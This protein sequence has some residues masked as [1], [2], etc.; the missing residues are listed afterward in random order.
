[1][2][3]L[4]GERT[5]RPTSLILESEKNPMKAILICLLALSFLAGMVASP[6]ESGC[7]AV[8]VKHWQVSKEFTLAVAEAMPAAGYDFKPKPEEMTF[9]QLMV[10]IAAQNSDSCADATGTKPPPSMPSSSVEPPVTDKVTAIK[11]L[12]V[13][14]DKCANE[15]EVMPP[16]Q[17]NREVYKFQGQPVLAN[18][19]LL[20]T[21]THAAH[22][23]A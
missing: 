6:S 5:A 13:S 2:A 7:K 12:T 20:Y 10:H 3:A 8:F 15:L 9:G 11:L 1:M 14:F 16:E 22:H 18:E 21:F 19:A 4:S 17:W 23:R